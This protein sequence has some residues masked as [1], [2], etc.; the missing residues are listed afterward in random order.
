MPGEICATFFQQLSKKSQ[1]FDF[2]PNFEFLSKIK[3]KKK[4]FKMLV[5]S[6]AMTLNLIAVSV[7]GGAERLCL[8]VLVDLPPCVAD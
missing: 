6:P 4:M 2:K 5:G 3:K 1:I 8:S 7:E